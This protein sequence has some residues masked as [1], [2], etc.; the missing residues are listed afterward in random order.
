MN[1]KKYDNNKV[2]DDVKKMLSS[3]PVAKKMSID[4]MLMPPA[5]KNNKPE[6]SKYF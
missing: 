3:I 1:T 6:V 2:S 5:K 4:E